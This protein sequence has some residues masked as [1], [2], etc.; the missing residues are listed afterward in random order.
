[1]SWEVSL[2][3]AIVGAVSLS[4]VFPLTILVR[5]WSLPSGAG[6]SR[7]SVALNFVLFL[8]A[9]LGTLA[10]F[11]LGFVFVAPSGQH[12]SL[13]TPSR[14]SHSIL[15][16]VIATFTVLLLLIRSCSFPG[17]F[18]SPPARDHTSRTH[19]LVSILIV[20]LGFACVYTSFLDWAYIIT[21][22]W[23]PIF[24]GWIAFL[25]LAFL[26]GEC[27]RSRRE[28]IAAAV[29]SDAEALLNAS[30]APA[31]KKSLGRN[32]LLKEIHGN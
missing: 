17:D 8:M 22:I 2:A 6:S 5:Q 19:D 23:Y 32:N 3:H 14:G 7:L 27:L 24:G 25:V 18:T 26:I 13:T 12:L 9:S 1:M 21:W 29:R 16:I 11:A 28:K 4:V 31:P 15:G 10:S 30:A 20:L